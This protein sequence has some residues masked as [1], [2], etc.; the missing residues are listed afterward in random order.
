MT[1]YVSTDIRNIEKDIDNYHKSN[2]LLTLPFGTAAWYL[3]AYYEDRALF[4]MIKKPN[5][6]MHE[7]AALS[8]NLVVELQYPISW[9]WFGC[10]PGGR[11]SKTHNEKYY[12]ACHELSELAIQYSAFVVAYTYA[13]HGTL[14]LVLDDTTIIPTN[15][16]FEDS[17]FEAYGRLVAQEELRP[18]WASGDIMQAIEKSLTVTKK[19]FR[20]SLG[21]RLLNQVIKS[22]TQIYENIFE[23]PDNW[24]FSNYSLAEFRRMEKFILAFSI[25]H[26]LARYIAATK[27]CE[28]LGQENCLIVLSHD[29]LVWKLTKHADVTP[30]VAKFFI[31]DITYGGKGI[32]NPDP[33]LQ[34]LIKANNDEYIIMPSLFISNSLERN[35]VVLFNR[36]PKE[37]DVYSK[38]V[39]EKESWLRQKIQD[40]INLSNVRY[41][42]GRLEKNSNLPDI[43]L[44]IISD[45]EKIAFIVE[46]KWFIGPSEPRE[47]LEKTEEIQKGISQSLLFDDISKKAPEILYDFLKVDKSY[48]LVFLVLS[49]NFI[50]FGTIQH[51]IIPVVNAKHFVKKLNTAR[52]F[53][54]VSDWLKK[55]EYLPVEGHDYKIIEDVSQI[56]K[57]KLRWYRI[58]PLRRDAF[59]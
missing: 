5:P 53:A 9:L 36:L 23:L 21:K 32:N 41:I 58:Q 48:T 6:T 39:Q 56:G 10:Q 4:S 3:L 16:I 18:D 35:L 59:I 44:A 19:K 13:S 17:R 38:L 22:S 49:A 2:P 47:V 30:K 14:K 8:D 33:A 46:L 55:G 15:N 54:I 29:Q 28:G 50:G 1:D 52:S 27:G 40:E 25:I 20:Y 45:E 24:K 26:F 12:T 42:H 51:P 31:E 43:D 34:P 37:R 11:V 7:V 57:W